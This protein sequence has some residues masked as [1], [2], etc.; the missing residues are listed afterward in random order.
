V[1]QAFSGIGYTFNNYD[2]EFGWDD[3]SQ[4]L[5]KGQGF[6]FKNAGPTNI[7]LT[8]T[9]D[10]NQ[11]GSTNNFTANALK[12]T[13][14]DTPQAG[15]LETDFSLPVTPTPGSAATLQRWL[16][17]SQSFTFDNYDTEFGWDAPPLVTVG[18]GFFMKF[19]SNKSWVR[20][21]T[22]P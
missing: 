1:V 18:E 8:F 21:F 12:L 6:F 5:T 17:G 15:D 7:T 16:V 11:S 14:L 10:V 13:T 19:V 9:G 2:T 20:N 4:T 22:V 3:P